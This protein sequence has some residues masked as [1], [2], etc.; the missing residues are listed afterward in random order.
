[1]PLWAPPMPDCTNTDDEADD[2]VCVCLHKGEGPINFS[3]SKP[4]LSRLE[5]FALIRQVQQSA[6]PPACASHPS[7]ALR[8]SFRCFVGSQERR[9]GAYAFLTLTLS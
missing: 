1:M 5:M 3:S 9:N 4:A 6:V 7:D 2:N 8:A